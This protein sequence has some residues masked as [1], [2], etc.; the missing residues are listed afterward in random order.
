MNV[1]G[2][3]KCIRASRLGG[4]SGRG[5]LVP[6]DHGLTMGPIGG[7]ETI[8]K[9]A[10]WLGNPAINGIIA[11]KGTVERLGGAG[12][13]RNLAVVVHINGMTNIGESPDTKEL[14]VSVE[15]AVRLGA[16]AVSVQANFR[17][18]NHGHNLRMLAGAED[19]AARFG[20]PLLAM[21]YDKVPTTDDQTRLTRQRH[22]IRAA[23]EL[24]VDIVKTDP[25]RRTD[26]VGA[27]LEGI[28]EDVAVYFSGGALGAGEDLIELAKQVATGPARGLCVGRNVFQRAD[29]HSILAELRQALD[30]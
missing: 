22:L 23:M 8:S 16:D 14:L 15:S 27:L 24:G 7:I 11:H 12:L 20:L 26:Q 17:E 29:P 4:V 9:V 10:G 30:G 3:G 2:A 19:A 18:D 21:V 1:V 6:M 5:L 13:L 28:G 25:P